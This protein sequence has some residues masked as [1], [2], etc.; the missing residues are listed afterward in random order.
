MHDIKDIY[1]DTICLQEMGVLPSFAKPVILLYY[2]LKPTK[3]TTGPNGILQEADYVH[4]KCQN[5]I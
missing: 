5:I 2:V 3:K 4:I 1:Y